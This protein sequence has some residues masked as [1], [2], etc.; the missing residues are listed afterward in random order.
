MPHS[1]FFAV[2]KNQFF[3]AHTLIKCL[4]VA[5]GNKNIT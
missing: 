1:G 5:S 3:R 4:N 2:K